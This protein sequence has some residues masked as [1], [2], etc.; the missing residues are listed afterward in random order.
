MRSRSMKSSG[1]QFRY[2]PRQCASCWSSTPP[3]AAASPAT[4]YAS[5]SSC[6]FRQAL[7]VIGAYQY[8]FWMQCMKCLSRSSGTLYL[9][10]TSAPYRNAV[11]PPDRRKSSLSAPPRPPPLGTRNAPTGR[12]RNHR[13]SRYSQDSYSTRL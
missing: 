8:H 3:A 10:R 4:A 6:P 5:R 1:S 9:H 12:V 7:R 2:L 13:R 11:R